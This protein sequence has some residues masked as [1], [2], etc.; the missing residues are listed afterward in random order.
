MQ[1]VAIP[2]Y[3]RTDRSTPRLR[4][5]ATP[6]W[7]TVLIPG[8]WQILLESVDP[9]EHNGSDTRAW[10][11]PD[12]I[13][14]RH[15]IGCGGVAARRVRDPA[16]GRVIRVPDAS[17]V[18]ESWREQGGI[19]VPLQYQVHA[20]GQTHQ[21]Y[22]LR[23]DTPA[24]AHHCWAYERP[25]PG[26][27]RTRMETDEHARCVLY[28]SWANDYMGGVAAHNLARLR[29]IDERAR[30]QCVAHA[31]RNAVARQRLLVVE[32][33][34]RAM[35]WLAH[36]DGELRPCIG[37]VERTADP[38]GIGMLP[39]ELRRMMQTLTPQQRAA[40]LGDTAQAATVPAPS[41]IDDMQ[42]DAAGDDDGSVVL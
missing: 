17:R 24:G 20:H 14:V 33:R 25:V 28:A 18:L 19:E 7:S 15:V 41:P 4:L 9:D 29:A 40:L 35:G 13:F 38:A 16:T 1:P 3:H 27:G 23:Y 26:P 31:E 32:R 34:M 8:H 21:Q 5:P 39:A 36:D 37:S 30:A 12:P 11:V 22:I 6:F 2:T 42:P 10:V